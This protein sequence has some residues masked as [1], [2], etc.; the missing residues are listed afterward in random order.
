[1]SDLYQEP[2][3]GFSLP[4]SASLKILQPVLEVLPQHSAL[5]G[6][7]GEILYVNRAWRSFAAA[8]GAQGDSEV[9]VGANYLQVCSRAAS[10]GDYDAATIRDRLVELLKNGSGSFTHEYAC[11]GPG[12][13]RWFAMEAVALQCDGNNYA[14]VFHINQTLQYRAQAQL[15]GSGPAPHSGGLICICAACKRVRNTD[16]SWSDFESTLPKLTGR[17]LTHGICL[18]CTEQLYPDLL[19]EVA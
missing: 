8:N 5:L 14:A 11:H 1:M 7:T 6:P 2:L 10:H 13:E 15:A 19:D 9:D 16:G 12:I 3:L 18:S 4:R 17:D